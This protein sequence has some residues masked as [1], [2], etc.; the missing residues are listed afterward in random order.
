MP[1]EQP[2]IGPLSLCW[3]SMENVPLADMIKAASEA[4]YP[5]ITISPAFYHRAQQ[6]GLDDHGLTKLLNDNGLSVSGIDPVLSWVPGAF[7]LDDDSDFA[8]ASRTT[9]DE[10]IRIAKVC[11]APLINL[12]QG[13][14]EPVTEEQL[15]EAFANACDKAATANL[16]V[17]LEFT[18][19]S[20]INSLQ[21]AWRIISEAGCDNGGVMI[22]SWHFFQSGGTL[23]DLETVPAE[24]I[25]G[26]QI[27]G[28]NRCDP[29]DWIDQTMNHRG[30]PDEGDYAV[31]DLLQCL[32][33]LGA[34]AAVD[35]EIFNAALREQTPLQRARQTFNASQKVLAT[36]ANA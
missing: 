28:V 1:D 11:G 21:A 26:I 32:Y 16:K 17:S 20:D 33:R 8:I 14:G 36:V 10:N 34:K 23:A 2:V 31:G 27:N 30:M 18:P 12:P 35:V 19:F 22:D 7:Q 4:A 6:A 29:Q 24:R 25:Y 9:V 15:I 3:G 5:A 13:F